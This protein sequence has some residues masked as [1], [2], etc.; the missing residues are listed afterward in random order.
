MVSG[1]K[2][3]K[4]GNNFIMATPSILS[5]LCDSSHISDCNKDYMKFYRKQT[6]ALMDE[7]GWESKIGASKQ[8]SS[9]ATERKGMFGFFS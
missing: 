8:E 2:G 7:N 9:K 3:M 6:K 5:R 4:R 1:L